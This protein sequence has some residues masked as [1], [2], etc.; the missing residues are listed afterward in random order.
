MTTA[1]YVRLWLEKASH[2]LQIARQGMDRPTN[3]W[4]TDMLS[5]HAQ[6]AI[7]KSLKAQLILLREEP[8]RTHSLEVLLEAIQRKDPDFPK[9]DFGRLTEFAVQHRYPDDLTQP[10]I[11]ETQQFADLAR[12]VHEYVSL[13][14][15]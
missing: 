9:F 5:F 7:E 4:V 11:S 8:P 10:S 12:R 6:Q 14:V 13:R 1:E 3:E 15:E 2:D